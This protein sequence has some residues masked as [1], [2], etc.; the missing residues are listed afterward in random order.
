LPVLYTTPNQFSIVAD[1]LHVHSFTAL[2]HPILLL[3]A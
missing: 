2:Q 1:A 3:L